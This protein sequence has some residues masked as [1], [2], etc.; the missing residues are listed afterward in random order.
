MLPA[1]KNAMPAIAVTPGLPTYPPEPNP[2]SLFCR[3]T[4]NLSPRSIAATARGVRSPSASI[5]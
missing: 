1:A 3:V 5:G 4:K 2:P